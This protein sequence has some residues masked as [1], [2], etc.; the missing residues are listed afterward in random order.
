VAEHLPDD[1]RQRDGPAGLM[2]F[3][4]SIR[5]S[6]L[7]VVPG[8]LVPD[9]GFILGHEMVGR[10]REL[11]PAV[12]LVR[13]H[14]Q[15]SLRARLVP[16]EPGDLVARAVE[17]ARPGHDHPSPDGATLLESGMPEY[18]MFTG[19]PVEIGDGQTQRWAENLVKA[20]F[21]VLI[22]GVVLSAIL[23]PLTSDD[24]GALGLAVTFA[25]CAGLL[26]IRQALLAERR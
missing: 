1:T 4:A 14:A 10:I 17:G 18:E 20:V 15:Q 5:G 26:V 11:G 6:D 24:V 19:L 2:P 13:R 23:W 22:V 16:R 7:H 8:D 25:L 3:A 9:T 12:K 21:A